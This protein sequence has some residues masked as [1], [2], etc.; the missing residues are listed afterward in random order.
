MFLHRH[1]SSQLECNAHAIIPCLQPAGPPSSSQR[2]VCLAAVAVAASVV[3][4]TL[5][6]VVVASLQAVQLLYSQEVW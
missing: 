4:A 3:Q 6:L 5:R 2:F 1:R